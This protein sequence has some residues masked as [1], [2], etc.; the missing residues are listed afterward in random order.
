MEK[1]LYILFTDLH[2]I[3][4]WF[5][6]PWKLLVPTLVLSVDLFDKAATNFSHFSH[7]RVPTPPPCPPPSPPLSLLSDLF[8]LMLQPKLPDPSQFMVK[9]IT[10]LWRPSFIC[11]FTFTLSHSRSTLLSSPLLPFNLNPW[12]LEGNQAQAGGVVMMRDMDGFL[13]E[14]SRFT[15][16]PSS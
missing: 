13:K 9:A 3:T 4:F 14:T 15:F 1:M 16:T 2:L 10:T 5:Y 8:I 6:I 11:V 12:R 7:W